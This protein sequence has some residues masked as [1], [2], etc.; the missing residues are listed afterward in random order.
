M[1]K[2]YNR[3]AKIAYDRKF[4]DRKINPRGSGFEALRKDMEKHGI[5][6]VADTGLNHYWVWVNGNSIA[7]ET[8]DGFMTLAAVKVWWKHYKR[9][10]PL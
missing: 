1:N 4:G 6:L 8:Q 7:G 9:K 2:L 5:E 10:H 3:I